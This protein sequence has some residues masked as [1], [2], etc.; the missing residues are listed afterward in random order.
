[1][2]AVELWTVD[3]RLLQEFEL[4]GDI[5]V[6]AHEMKAALLVL[7]DFVNQCRHVDTV[8]ILAAA[9]Q[10]AMVVGYFE[11]SAGAWRWVQ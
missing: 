2:K 6:Q 9:S 3:P 11:R 8:A 7:A 5:R 4:A 10:D 1:V